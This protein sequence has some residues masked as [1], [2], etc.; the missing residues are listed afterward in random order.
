MTAEEYDRAIARRDFNDLCHD[1][2]E[3][4]EP[5]W[6]EPEDNE[7]DFSAPPAPVGSEEEWDHPFGL[8]T[9]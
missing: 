5:E 4:V 8:E 6:E 3:I 7:P 2:P 9:I 1:E